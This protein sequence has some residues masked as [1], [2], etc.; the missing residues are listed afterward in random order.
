MID[1]ARADVYRDVRPDRRR[2]RRARVRGGERI[3][4][5]N[6]SSSISRS[7]IWPSL[8]AESLPKTILPGQQEEGG[9]RPFAVPAPARLM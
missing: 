4:R 6:T 7:V 1:G 8:F 3:R 9:P 5:C 2:A